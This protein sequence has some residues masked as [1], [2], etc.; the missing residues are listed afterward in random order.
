MKKTHWTINIVILAGMITFGGYHLL[1]K[2][3]TVYIEVDNN[4]LYVGVHKDHKN[5]L[6]KTFFLSKYLLKKEE[7]EKIHKNHLRAINK[8]KN[9]PHA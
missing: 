5:I 2:E 7:V 1:K 6:L 3:R 4:L 8:L 9:K